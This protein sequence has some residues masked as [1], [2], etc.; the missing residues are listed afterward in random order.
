MPSI[1]GSGVIFIKSLQKILD[2][3][4]EKTTRWLPSRK[5]FQGGSGMPTTNKNGSLTIE[6]WR[7]VIEKLVRTIKPWLNTVYLSKLED[8]NLHLASPNALGQSIHERKTVSLDEVLKEECISSDLYESQGIFGTAFDKNGYSEHGDAKDNLPIG[9]QRIWGLTRSGKWIKGEIFLEAGEPKNGRCFHSVSNIR[10]EKTNIDDILTFA[11]PHYVAERIRKAVLDMHEGKKRSIYDFEYKVL[12]P[13]IDLY[14]QAEEVIKSR[15]PSR[16]F[17]IT[18]SSKKVRFAGLAEYIVDGRAQL[19]TAKNKRRT[20][21][22]MQ[23]QEG[24]FFCLNC[25]RIA[26]HEKCD[27]K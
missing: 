9:W 14:A 19:T 4:I 17:K 24:E 20:T 23:L 7:S 10:L 3:G 18:V 16:T 5:K 8:T 1:Y 25:W 27:K 6:E 21:I 22:R 13:V 12:N 26:D 15:V 11:N 2:S